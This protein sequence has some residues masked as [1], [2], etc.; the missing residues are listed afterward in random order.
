MK[1]LLILIGLAGFISLHACKK[2]PV[3][4]PKDFETKDGDGKDQ[5]SPYVGTWNYTKVVMS[6]GT[7]GLQGQSFG[8]FV[9]TGKDI[10]G[11]VT[12]TQNPN[13]FTA[14]LEYTA[15]LTLTVFGQEQDRDMPVEKRTIT[16]DWTESN[17]EIS[18]IA[19]DGSDITIL[20]SSSSKVV[21][22]GTFEETIS[23]SQ[24]FSLE[25]ISDVEITIEK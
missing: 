2:P 11:S 10:K 12:V 24:Q 20:S 22:K 5:E 21:F 19:D 23:L 16:G 6:N 4:K 7:L 9:G 18:L 14:E 15:A 8:T 13:R 25:A 17:G 1:K 3:P